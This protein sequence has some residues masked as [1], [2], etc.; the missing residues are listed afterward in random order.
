LDEAQC[1]RLFDLPAKL[2][3]RCEIAA[4]AAAALAEAQAGRRQMLLDEI[5]ARNGR[6]FDAEMDKLDR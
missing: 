6:W 3:D 1:R 4:V 5:T 2:G